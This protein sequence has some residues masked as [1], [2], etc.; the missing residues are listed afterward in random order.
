MALTID[1][2]IDKLTVEHGMN[3]AE[4]GDLVKSFFDDIK[5]RLNNGEDVILP[6][7]GTFFKSKKY[8]H[9]KRRDIPVD[10]DTPAWHTISFS[11][12]PNLLA[13]IQRAEVEEARRERQD[14]KAHAGH[15]H[16]STLCMSEETSLG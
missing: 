7:I 8:Y 4:A 9:R 13:R 11:T 2:I 3:R 10:E 12:H 5:E 6:S 15:V 1:D 16:Q 14:A